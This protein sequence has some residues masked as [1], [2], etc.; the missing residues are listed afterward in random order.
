[1]PESFPEF[2]SVKVLEDKID[3]S[4][5]FFDDKL[6][7]YDQKNID[8]SDILRRIPYPEFPSNT[9]YFGSH[10]EISLEDAAEWDAVSELVDPV[11]K[12]FESVKN[13]DTILRRTM[14]YHRRSSSN[15]KKHGLFE[16]EGRH[17]RHRKFENDKLYFEHPY[18]MTFFLP[19]DAP[20]WV[21][22]LSLLH[23][24]IEDSPEYWILKRWYDYDK[25]LESGESNGKDKRLSREELEIIGISL[26]KGKEY[27][28]ISDWVSNEKDRKEI[29]EDKTDEIIED[30]LLQLGIQ[31]NT[32][33]YK[34]LRRNID[35]FIWRPYDKY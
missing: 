14:M 16:P 21:V 23:D 27:A 20:D 35:L 19:D 6:I 10:K 13:L 5:T 26:K 7:E 34:K 1:M 9:F 31:H 8:V 24:A 17:N 32:H 33:L 22:M 4:M 30:V 3:R 2:V 18:E 25:E 28:D 11:K 12:K 15:F 29:F